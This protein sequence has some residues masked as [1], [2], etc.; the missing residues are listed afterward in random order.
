MTDKTIY[1]QQEQEPIAEPVNDA[2][3]LPELPDDDAD[4]TPDLARKIIAKYQALVA[5]RI[6]QP[7]SNRQVAG[8]IPAERASPS[9]PPQQP[10]PD[11]ARLVG[12]L[13]VCAD[14]ARASADEFTYLNTAAREML[15]NAARAICGNAANEIERLASIRPQDAV[16]RTVPDATFAEVEDGVSRNLGPL[17]W[18]EPKPLT[19]HERRANQMA[20]WW[21]HDAEAAKD[22]GDHLYYFAPASRTPPPYKTQRHVTAIIDVASDGTLAGVELINDMPPPPLHHSQEAPAPH[23]SFPSRDT[24]VKVL[25]CPNG[26]VREDDCWSKTPLYQYGAEADAIL[27]LFGVNQSQE[28]KAK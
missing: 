19:P 17:R 27:K 1:A 13:S 24:L 15:R 3:K 16:A 22:I 2:Y 14:I 10:K 8:S 21:T 7:T 25:C 9:L 23:N 28:V 5:Q 20:G 6:E 4:F 18:V 12:Q 26:C 11:T